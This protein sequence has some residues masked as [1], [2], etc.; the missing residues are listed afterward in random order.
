M[1]RDT[2]AILARIEHGLASER[3]AID[4]L[5]KRLIRAAA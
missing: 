3:A 1:L 4:A 5:L 2:D